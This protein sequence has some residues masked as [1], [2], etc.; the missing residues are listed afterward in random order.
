MTTTSEWQIGALCES[1][2][3]DTRIQ[4]AR[5]LPHGRSRQSMVLTISGDSRPTTIRRSDDQRWPIPNVLNVRGNSRPDLCANSPLSTQRQ[6]SG[7]RVQ[8]RC[9]RSIPAPQPSSDTNTRRPSSVRSV[10]NFFIAATSL[11]REAYLL[12]ES[13]AGSAGPP[14]DWRRLKLPQLPDKTPI[15]EAQS[16]EIDYPSQQH[17]RAS[18]KTSNSPRPSDPFAALQ[19]EETGVTKPRARTK[20]Q[21]APSGTGRFLLP[22]SRRRVAVLAISQSGCRP[23]RRSSRNGPADRRGCASGRPSDD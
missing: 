22:V 9:I 20:K 7:S 1:V 3:I 5:A 15:A 18:G 14:L 17:D 8:R 6:P 13:I 21:P 19:S 4:P 10:M 2:A 23:P 12:S 16:I 11:R